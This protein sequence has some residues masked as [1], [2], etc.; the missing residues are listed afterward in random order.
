MDVSAISTA[1][2]SEGIAPG[3]SK[4]LFDVVA[5]VMASITNNGIVTGAEVAQL[6]VGLPN[7]APES[8]PNQLRGFNK[9]SLKA[10]ESGTVVFELGKKDLSHWVIDMKAWVVLSGSF[11][12][13]VGASS[14]DTR[15]IGIIAV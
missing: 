10:S 12:I 7:S 8:P 1:A 3:G 11:E 15:L 14:R 5:T 13:L 4:S 9:L 6:C 2:P